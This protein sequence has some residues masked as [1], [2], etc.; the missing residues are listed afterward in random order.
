MGPPVRRR[1]DNSILRWQARLDE[2]W[3]DRIL[4]W[5]GAA[6]L[7]AVLVASATARV[8]SGDLPPGMAGELQ[9]IW[10]L[11]ERS[12]LESSLHGGADVLAL[13][14]SAFRVI[15]ALVATWVPTTALL[16]TVQSMLLA[17]TVVPLWRM[18]RDVASLRVGAAAALVLAYSCN[19][20]M[21]SLNLSGFQPEVLALPALVLG[22]WAGLTDRTWLL[23]LSVGA[24]LAAG[25]ELALAVV[26]M[27]LLLTLNDRRRL[28]VAATVTGAAWFVVG[29]FLVQPWLDPS[30]PH[31]AHMADWG[32]S[33]SAVLV[34]VVG[35]PGSVLARM[36]D[37]RST[38]IVVALLAPLLFLPLLV[39]RFA[40]GAVPPGVAA[41]LASEPADL[42]GS[43]TA[44]ALLAFALVA[45]T[46]ALH[47]LGRIGTDR[48]NVDRRLLVVLSLASVLFFV[49]EGAHTPQGHPWRWHADPAGEAARRRVEELVPPAAAV[50]AEP[51]SLVGLAERRELHVFVPGAVPDAESAVEGVDVLVLAEDDLAHWTGRDRARFDVGLR[52]QGFDNTYASGGLELW[53]RTV[54]VPSAPPVSLPADPDSGWE[55]HR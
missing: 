42:W 48:I 11:Q 54:E 43:G 21:H 7:L 46:F 53:V 44:V 52:A 1:I 47:R 19:P 31:I 10:L 55:T 15:L 35:D 8:R 40:V 14:L 25:T 34:G 30:D 24:C 27:G 17:V 22:V 9:A 28:G 39:P 32:D 33:P 36:A 50:R 45:T 12:G 18:A 5:V 51:A 3:A 29:T 2:P 23:A 37:E 13:D 20:V 49:N 26:G 38:A 4:P 6:V 41:I 16:V